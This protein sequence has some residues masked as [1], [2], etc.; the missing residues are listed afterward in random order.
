MNDSNRA[1]QKPMPQLDGVA[2]RPDIAEG[3]PKPMHP[4]WEYIT[5]P[6]THPDNT[7]AAALSQKL[8]TAVRRTQALNTTRT[9]PMEQ[10]LIERMLAELSVLA[11][12]GSQIMQVWNNIQRLAIEGEKYIRE[13]YLNDDFTK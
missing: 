1:P 5:K 10:E 2:P 9:P 3:K 7:N 6:L 8:K 12:N 11:V 4:N 13:Q